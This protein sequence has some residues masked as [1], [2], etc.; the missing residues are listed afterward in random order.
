MALLPYGAP[1]DKGQLVTVTSDPANGRDGQMILN[2]VTGEVKIYFQSAWNVL[3]TL[4]TGASR[5]LLENGDFY[6]L[7][8][9]EKLI[10]G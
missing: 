1:I 6:L 7:E 5:L 2:T 9:G 8:N 10:L 4:T 3:H